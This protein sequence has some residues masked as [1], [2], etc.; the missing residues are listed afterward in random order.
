MVWLKGFLRSQPIEVEFAISPSA[1]RSF[2]PLC[3][4]AGLPAGNSFSGLLYLEGRGVTQPCD[5][6]R[7]GSGLFPLDPRLS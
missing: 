1:P 5:P 6:P 4:C 2:P 3:L 7:P